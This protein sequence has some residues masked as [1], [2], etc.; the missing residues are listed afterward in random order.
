MCFYDQYT[1]A[2]NCG[3][4]G[5]FRQHCAKEYR[6]GETCGMKLVM[7]TYQKAEKCKL[8]EKISTK[9]RTLRKEEDNVARWRQ[10]GGRSASIEKSEGTIRTI[11]DDIYRME[12]EIYEKQRTLSW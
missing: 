10:S 4:W 11:K 7:N 12:C 1:M 2:C 9:K 6:T 8:H 3:K 5:N